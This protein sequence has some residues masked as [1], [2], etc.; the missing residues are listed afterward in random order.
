ML[1]SEEIVCF[2]QPHSGNHSPVL[3]SVA[4]RSS[5]VR[6][7]L[8]DLDSYFVNDS[9][10]MFLLFYKQAARELAYKLTVIFRHLVKRDSFPAC[11]R[12]AHAVPVPK[13]F[14]LGCWRLQAYLYYSRLII[15][16]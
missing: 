13:K 7:L 4:F 6:S 16:I 15:Y 3:C 11:W 10:T 1:S 5:F 8:P 9:D 14:L 12:L 2:Q